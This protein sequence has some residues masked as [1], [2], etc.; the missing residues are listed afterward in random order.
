MM[1]APNP[2]KPDK[3]QARAVRRVT[4]QTMDVDA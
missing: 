1:Q 3:R 4:L 2:G